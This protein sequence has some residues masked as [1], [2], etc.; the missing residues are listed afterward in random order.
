MGTW[1][2][3]NREKKRGREGE[4]GNG[5]SRIYNID[6]T[7]YMNNIYFVYDTAAVRSI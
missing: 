1:N 7:Y 4:E 5:C 3:D 6:L 2:K